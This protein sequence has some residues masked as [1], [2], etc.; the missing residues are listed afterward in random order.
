MYSKEI[1]Q[2][3]L[4]SYKEF[5][6]IK[7]TDPKRFSYYENLHNDLFQLFRHIRNDLSHNTIDGE[8]P[9]IVSDNLLDSIDTCISMMKEKLIERSIPMEKLV[10]ATMNANV[11]K[12][13][14]IMNKRNF[15]YIPILENK[16]IS[17]VFSSD[18]LLKYLNQHDEI[19]SSLTIS[20][21]S[22]FLIKDKFIIVPITTFT[23]EIEELFI[24]H[25]INV[26]FITKNGQSNERIIGMVTSY[27]I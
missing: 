17:Y 1:T 8:F 23:Y 22:N 2:K 6:T 25:K 27:E 11:S 4:E 24:Q 10:Y 9:F 15:Q 21:L 3:F 19:N 16:E 7:D 18:V 12:V 26:A 14:K 5:E 13:I 20:D